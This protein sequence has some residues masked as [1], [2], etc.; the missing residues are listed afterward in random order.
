MIYI[1][2]IGEFRAICITFHCMNRS[3]IPWRENWFPAEQAIHGIRQVGLRLVQ[4]AFRF[5]RLLSCLISGEHRFLG[6]KAI[7]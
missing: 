5:H 2:Q 4:G 7:A 3:L 6:R 1:Q